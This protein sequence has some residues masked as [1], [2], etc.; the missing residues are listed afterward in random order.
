[1]QV[2]I[3]ASSQRTFDTE[4][5][6]MLRVAAGAASSDLTKQIERRREVENR[7]LQ[8]SESSNH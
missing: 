6:H 7:R 2:L 8:E 5:D 3:Y 1:M 4:L